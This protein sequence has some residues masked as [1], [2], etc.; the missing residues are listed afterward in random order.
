MFSAVLLSTAPANKPLDVG[1][2]DAPG[3]G[4]RPIPLPPGPHYASWRRRGFVLT[5]GAGVSQCA[6][7]PCDTI[8]LGG[9]GRIQAGYR[10]GLYSLFVTVSGG[11]GLLDV[12]D[13]E[14]ESASVT[15]AKGG[16][17]FLFTG[18]GLAVH[19]VDFGRVDPFISATIGF[20]RVHE[21]LR[22]DEGQTDRVFARGGVELAVG[23]DVFVARRV[24]IGPR[25]GVS[26]P[27]AGS[28]C[29]TTEG[30]Q[31]CVNTGDAIRSQLRAFERAKRRDLP[32]V[33]SLT[34]NATFVLGRRKTKR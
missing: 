9:Q 4:E 3:Q 6:Q 12:P 31:E 30:V 10:I 21:R 27:F 28:I 14:T 23:L 19:P 16:L 34:A 15:N 24:A 22:S 1:A 20:D 33:W 8:V 18:V 13:F 7:P 5:G 32:R 26:F 11:G 25:F 17:S 2:A 29:T